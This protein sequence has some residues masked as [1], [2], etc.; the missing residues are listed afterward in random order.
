[1]SETMEIKRDIEE[2]RLLKEECGLSFEEIV[3]VIVFDLESEL[4]QSGKKA[5][6][7][8]LP[9][10]EKMTEYVSEL[11]EDERDYNCVLRHM[12]GFNSDEDAV[13]KGGWSSR[14]SCFKYALDYLKDNQRYHHQY[15]RYI[16]MGG[17]RL[18]SASRNCDDTGETL[19]EGMDG[20]ALSLTEMN[21]SSLYV[22]IEQL[23]DEIRLCDQKREQALA[24]M[25]TLL[26]EVRKRSEELPRKNEVGLPVGRV[27]IELEGAISQIDWSYRSLRV[28]HMLQLD[29]TAKVI[30]YFSDFQNFVNGRQITF[31]EW[32]VITTTLWRAGLLELEDITEVSLNDDIEY[33]IRS[34]SY[35]GIGERTVRCLQRS[36]VNDVQGLVCF[37]ADGARAGWRKVAKMRGFGSKS[38]RHLIENMLTWV[39]RISPELC[40]PTKRSNIVALDFEDWT[41]RRLGIYHIETIGELITAC[42]DENRFR[43]LRHLDSDLYEAAIE[44]LQR[45]GFMKA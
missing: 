40:S 3:Y 33:A 7:S 31:W 8:E 21:V 18:W 43:G 38:E 11:L 32:S 16:L 45:Y 15:P 6:F 2:L 39:V 20:D 5:V 22:R 9:C 1:M 13:L 27:E 24:M 44:R 34:L 26:K 19:I 10:R 23:L 14:E 25:E 12:L 37:F 4:R 35:G 29:T 30:E 42:E 17:G 36:G 28:L 41:L